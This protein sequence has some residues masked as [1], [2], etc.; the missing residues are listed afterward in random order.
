[1]R[2][3]FNSQIKL[4]GGWEGQLSYYYRAPRKTTQGR[5]L[6][7]H[8]LNFNVAK[9]FLD[10]RARITLSARDIFNTRLRRW[11]TET[12]NY[13]SEGEFR[14]HATRRFRLSFT[15]KLKREKDGRS[16]EQGSRPRD[17]R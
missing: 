15:Y 12:E 9:K 11:E 3:R 5:R 6:A 8:S 2:G 10:K 7:S 1:M 13:Y 4:D 16:G 17:S 14:W